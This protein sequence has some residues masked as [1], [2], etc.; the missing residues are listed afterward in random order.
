MS[1][2][3]YLSIYVYL[4]LLNV[5]MYYIMSLSIYYIAIYIYGIAS[6]FVCCISFCFNFCLELYMPSLLMEK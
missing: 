5:Y 6:R 2:S 1:I 3:I 4:Y